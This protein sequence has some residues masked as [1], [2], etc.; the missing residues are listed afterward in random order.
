MKFAKKTAKNIKYKNWFV[1]TERTG[2]STRSKKN[3][4]GYK[5]IKFRTERFRNSAI[6]VMKK[7]LNEEEFKLKKALKKVD[8]VPREHC[9]FK[10][11]SVKI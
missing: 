4:N 2:I 7:M 9:L 8:C 6:P 10:P 1:E 3:A 11:I 5:P